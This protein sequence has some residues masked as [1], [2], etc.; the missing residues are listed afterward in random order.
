MKIQRGLFIDFED[1]KETNN[2]SKILK[3]LNTK[4]KTEFKLYKF[5]DLPIEKEDEL[6]YMEKQSKKMFHRASIML[7][8]REREFK[9]K[10]MLQELTNGNNIIAI[11]YCFFKI[12]NFLKNE[13]D[14][15]FAKQL[16][17]GAIR[18]DVVIY[19][20]VDN[21]FEGLFSDYTKFHRIDEDK[22]NILSENVDEVVKLYKTIKENYKNGNDNFKNNFYPYEIGEDLFI[23]WPS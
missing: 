4:L 12:A 21:N 2:D 10:D 1:F 9:R 23:N 11:N 17:R 20:N 14:L 19:H 8:A 15:N 5:K 16:F 13:Q 6:K 18:P 7:T 22:E 3:E